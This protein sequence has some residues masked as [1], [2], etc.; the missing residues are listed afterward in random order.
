MKHQGSIFVREP[1]SFVQVETLD[2][3]P[4]PSL[5]PTGCLAEDTAD[6]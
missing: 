6:L 2:S 5:P 3:S 1:P 4:P